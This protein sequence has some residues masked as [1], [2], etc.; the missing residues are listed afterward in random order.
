MHRDLK[1]DNI[2]VDDD[3]NLKVADFGF[4]TWKK[5]NRLVSYRGTKT[6]MAP[7]I[8]EHK[9]YDG[10][11]ADIFSAGVILFIIVQGIFPFS[12]ALTDNEHYKL[13]Y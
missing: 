9:V 1:L 11:Q 5:I 13:I 6:Y 3:L 12:D 2:L 10:R 4:A 8:K 7:E